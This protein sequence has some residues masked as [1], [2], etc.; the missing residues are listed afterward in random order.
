MTAPA[1][2]LP[3]WAWAL[4]APEAHGR[5]RCRPE[6]FRV[7]E[8]PLIEPEGSGNHL[9]LEIE[10][11]GANT[12]WVAGQL[13]RAAGVHPR[14]IGFAGMKD[15]NGVTRQW[16]SVGLQEAGRP[17]PQDWLI[18]DVTVL[19]HHRHTRKLK[20]GTL[21]GNRF[22]LVIRE[23]GGDRDLLEERLRTASDQGVPNYFGEQRFGHGGRNVERA[24]Q[25]LLNGGRVRRNQKSIF[26]SAARSFMFNNVL[27]ERVSQGNWNRLLDGELAQLDG[28][29][30]VFPC[31]LP[32]PELE[33]RCLDF[34]IHPTGP[35]PGKDG[36]QPAGP[37]L[38]L[39]N[40]ILGPEKPL[41]EALQRAGVDAARRA[42]RLIPAGLTWEFPDECLLLEFELPAGAYATSVLRE[43]VSLRPEPIS[44]E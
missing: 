34:D 16:F 40:E 30:S 39:E 31:E 27:S 12:N 41:I 36:K 43:L 15:R 8:I 4:G 3:R 44:G 35:L 32:D 1:A 5:I 7:H 14:E 6:D 29:H 37:A 33:K 24:R 21:R 18:E 2:G 23:F 10:K 20:R 42:L 17:D 13:S 26:L 25:W 22:R 28:S 19:Q 11:R 9:W 38:E